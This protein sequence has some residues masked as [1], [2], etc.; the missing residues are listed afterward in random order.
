MQM[1]K[2]RAQVAKFGWTIVRA[3]Q[4]IAARARVHWLTFAFLV[5]LYESPN[6]PKY[7]RVIK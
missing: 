6:K 7:V 5:P 3:L 4:M 1:S 2:V